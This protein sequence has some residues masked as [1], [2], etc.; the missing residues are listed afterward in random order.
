MKTYKVLWF[1][2]E[3][4][5]L[6]TIK[7]EA[8]IN[9]IELIGFS[10]AEEGIKEINSNY[11]FYDA[12]IVD[13]KF[14]SDTTHSGDAVEDAALF[15]VARALDKLEDKKKIPWFILSGQDSFTKQNNRIAT[16]YQDNKVFDKNVDEDFDQLWIDIKKAADLQLD[17]QIRHKFFRVFEVCNERYIGEETAKLL[18]NS[19]KAVSCE[20]LNL[21][22]EDLFNPI[23]KIIERLF[24]AFNKI[25][26]LP[27]EVFK[28][29]GW[30]N[31]S[32]IFLSGK[33]SSYRMNEE[34]LHPTIAFLLKNILQVIQD[35]SHSEGELKLKI[36]QHVRNLQTPN[37]YISVVYQLV[38]ILIW[39]KEYAENNPDPEKNKLKWTLIENS[40]ENAS[41][42]WI[43]GTIVKIA[44]NGYGTFK[45]NDSW[46]TLSIP[47]N[48]IKEYHL[49]ENENIELTTISDS[50]GTKTYTDKIKRITP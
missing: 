48:K 33:H 39:Y 6:E 9:N 42:T 36:D 13:G 4:A 21:D 44:D 5:Q 18:L 11:P 3:H 46:K 43:K 50:T 29:K 24:S 45:P 17:T 26:L 25:N 37:L 19:L 22:T 16:E 14:Y 32:S 7:D 41:N 40:N 30:I 8:L 2:D 12:V 23:R 10:N 15:K 27:N 31:Q 35:G 38:D 49:S 28:G 34:I 20:N 1:D 47:P